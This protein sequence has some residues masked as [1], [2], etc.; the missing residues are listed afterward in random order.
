MKSSIRDKAEGNAKLLQ[1][2][3]QEA[4]GRATSRPNL[5]DKGLAKQAEGHVQ[6]KVGDIKK[7]FD[8]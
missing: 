7:V 6:K 4:A 5:R 2:K 8:R 3:A 1:G